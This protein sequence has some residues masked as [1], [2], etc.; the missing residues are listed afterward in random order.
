MPRPLPENP[1]LDQLRRQARDRRRA[2]GT[3]HA[4]AL[5][6]VARDHGFPSWPALVR[7]VGLLEDLRWSSRPDGATEHADRGLVG[8]AC[9]IGRAHV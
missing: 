1:D 4:L 7:H 5:R 8:L 6:D 3:T 2:G 9:Q